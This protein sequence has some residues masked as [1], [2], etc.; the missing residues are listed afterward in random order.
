MKTY[1]WAIPTR[2]FHWLLAIGFAAAFLLGDSDFRNLHYAFGAFVGV[3]ILFRIFDGFF[4]PKYS[5][6]RDFPIGIKNQVEFVKTFFA[7]TKTYAG[8][9]PAASLVMLS[10]FIVGLL[11]SFSGFNI[12]ATEA[13]IFN[14][15]LNEELMEEMHEIFANLF[16][17]LVIFHL[18]GILADFIFHRKTGTYQSMFTG[19]KNIEAEN[20]KLST[21]HKIFSVIW[22]IVPFIFFVLANSL[23]TNN[24][25]NNESNKTEKYENE[26]DEEDDD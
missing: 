3:I 25:E 4:G 5:H 23:Q 14:I 1:I 15:G 7:K 18:A 6:F 2:I 21:F 12:Y 19:Y 20:V 26:E 24:Q 16:L 8:H 13:G 9:N 22:F 10:I 17:L 11:A